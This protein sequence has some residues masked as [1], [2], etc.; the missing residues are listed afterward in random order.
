MHLIGFIIKN[1]A[2]NS[3][4]AHK[5]ALIKKEFLLKEQHAQEKDV[6]RRAASHTR[7]SKEIDSSVG[8]NIHFLKNS[9][10]NTFY[11]NE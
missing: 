2:K 6:M 1:F 8:K 9:V 7:S 10:G 3:L 4:H 11:E 5:G